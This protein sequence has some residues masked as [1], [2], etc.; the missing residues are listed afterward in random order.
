MLSCYHKLIINHGT[1]CADGLMACT[2]LYTHLESTERSSSH[3]PPKEVSLC[4]FLSA[5]IGAIMVVYRS[6][7]DLYCTTT[8]SNNS[9]RIKSLRTRCSKR[10]S[11]HMTIYKYN[12]SYD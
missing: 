12:T 2:V 6:S 1:T 9:A 7:L 11:Y 4:H 3:H 8:S 10:V 5:I